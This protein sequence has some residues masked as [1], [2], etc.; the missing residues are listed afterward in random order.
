MSSTL[1]TNLGLRKP[2]HRDPETL[3]TWD[4]VL[5]N[6]FDMIDAAF[7][8]RSY[9]EQN[10]VTNSDALTASINKLDIKMFDV[11]SLSPTASQKAALAGPSGYAPNGLNP[12][13]TVSYVGG[14]ITPARKIII[15]AEYAGGVLWDAGAIIAGGSLTSDFEIVG[16]FG[17]NFYKW[18]STIGETY[19]AVVRWKAPELFT[20]WSVVANTAL[21]I[22]MLTEAAAATSTVG[23]TIY[24]DGVMGTPSVK[25]P[26]FG[27]AFTWHA[28]RHSGVPAQAPLL[29]YDATDP[30]LASIG[31]GDVLVIAIAMAS[32][33]KFVKIGDITLQYTG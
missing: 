25:G 20:G 23:V 28:E 2:S 3:E 8:I 24:K 14:L 19:Y 4:Y 17:Y 31:A 13:A 32:N 5:N 27:T 18:L 15:P 22:D 1:T 9:T 6:N 29:F 16:A 21:I 26:F 7:G 10:Y 12:Y 11:A 33:N 30:V